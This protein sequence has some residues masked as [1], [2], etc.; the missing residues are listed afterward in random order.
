[1][2]RVCVEHQPAATEDRNY[3]LKMGLHQQ[4][5]ISVVVDVADHNQP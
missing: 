5:S 2:A 1:M 3:L 4:V